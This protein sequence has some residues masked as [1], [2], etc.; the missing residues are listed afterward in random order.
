[1]DRKEA[2]TGSGSEV[3]TSLKGFTVKLPN[4]DSFPL[5]EIDE[6]LVTLDSPER[7]RD[8]TF[9]N[10]DDVPDTEAYRRQLATMAADDAARRKPTAD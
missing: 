5:S 10:D 7:S 6:H 3:I 4:G 9:A 8:A 1:M 2:E